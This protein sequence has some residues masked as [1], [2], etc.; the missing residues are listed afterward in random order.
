MNKTDKAIEAFGV[1]LTEPGTLASVDANVLTAALNEMLPKLGTEFYRHSYDLAIHLRVALGNAGLKI[2]RK[3][4][5]KTL[6]QLATE[7]KL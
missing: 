4:K 6:V 5:G 3:P 1:K 7:R 2:V